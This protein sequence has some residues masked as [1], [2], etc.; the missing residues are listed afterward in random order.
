MYLILTV[1]LAATAALG[2]YAIRYSS[3]LSEKSEQS[4][5]EGNALLG[6]QTLDRLDN[7]I[8]DSDR[9]LF[10]LVDLEH[11][12]EFKRRWSEIVNLSPAIEAA[13]IL[14]EHKEILPGGYV[15]KRNIE[16]AAAFRGLFLKKILPDLPLDTLK[17]DF[18]KHWHHEYDGEDE[19]QRREPS[20]PT[21]RHAGRVEQLSALS[22]G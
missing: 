21:R 1:V 17:A 14:D 7:F 11:L 5:I 13:V 19:I 9:Q 12:D 22:Y 6:V 10:E 4:I 15:S 2:R 3:Q 16:D 20:G 18:H 8:I